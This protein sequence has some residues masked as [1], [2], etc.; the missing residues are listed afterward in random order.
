MPEHEPQHDEHQHQH[1]IA[2]RR[3]RTLGG[4][5]YLA[6][7]T[8]TVLGVAV[9]VAGRAHAGIRVCGAAMLGGA[10][11]RLVLREEEAG[12]LGVRRKLV[13][14]TTMLVLGGGLLVLAGLLREPAP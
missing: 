13:D 1:S 9:V 14:V 6:V 4:I 5:A 2:P 10:V 8:T 3:P 11:A 7:L 12:M